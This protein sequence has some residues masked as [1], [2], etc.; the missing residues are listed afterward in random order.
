MVSENSLMDCM[1]RAA[2]LVVV[3][4]AVVPK[5]TVAQSHPGWCQGVGNK[6]GSIAVCNP[7]PDPS[8]GHSPP[9]ATPTYPVPT[10]VPQRT[11]QPSSQSAGTASYPVPQPIE[12][13]VPQLVQARSL[14]GSA[15]G[16][17]AGAAAGAAIALAGLVLRLPRL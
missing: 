17:L 12:Q 8:L 1:C 3:L 13:R 6:H 9:Q 16:S 5:D 7:S 11:P 14:A 4:G 10:P 2:V 15:A